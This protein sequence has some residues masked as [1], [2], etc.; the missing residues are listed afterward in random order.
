M[1]GILGLLTGWILLTPILVVFWLRLGLPY[2][3]WMAPFG[4]IAISVPMLAFSTLAGI[5]LI[6]RSVRSLAQR[7]DDLA[8]PR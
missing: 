3:E 7:D 8:P 6:A 2:M 1:L 4:G 5:A